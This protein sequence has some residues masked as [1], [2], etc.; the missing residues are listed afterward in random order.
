VY[1]K[2]G[3]P[4]NGWA[5]SNSNS[6]C[7]GL[8]APDTPLPVTRKTSPFRGCVNRPGKSGGP[9]CWLSRLV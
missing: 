8:L 6:Y 1:C 7:M 2:A 9:V 5:P 4:A 3:V